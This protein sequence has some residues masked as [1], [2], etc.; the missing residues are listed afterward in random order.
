MRLTR[1]SSFFPEEVNTVYGNSLKRYKGM[2]Y[3]KS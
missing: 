1:K 2:G 3:V